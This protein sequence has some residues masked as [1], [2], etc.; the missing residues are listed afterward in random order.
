M[1]TAMEVEPQL[2]N[3]GYVWIISE[4]DVLPP[5]EPS[6]SPVW[7]WVTGSAGNAMWESQQLG[8]SAG[9]IAKTT[10]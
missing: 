9:A 4:R 8:A 2:T 7:S 3:V 6:R 5:E 10:K 1:V